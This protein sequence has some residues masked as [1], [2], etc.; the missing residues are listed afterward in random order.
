MFPMERYRSGHNG[1]D[2]KSPKMTTC[3]QTVVAEDTYDVG[4]VQNVWVRICTS[5]DLTVSVSALSNL[6]AICKRLPI[7]PPHILTNESAV[8]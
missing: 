4:N 2:S 1:P 3:S 5:H 8:L 6:T 7:P